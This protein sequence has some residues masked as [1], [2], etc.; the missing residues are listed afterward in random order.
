MARK[1]KTAALDKGVLDEFDALVAEINEAYAVAD[2]FGVKHP[3]VITADKAPDLLRIPTGSLGADYASGGGIPVRR[4]TQI[5]G[6][7]GS[8]KSALAT[9]IVAEAQRICPLC[10]YYACR[11]EDRFLAHVMYVDP[12]GT[13]DKRHAVSQGVQ[14]DKVLHMR[15]DYAE[16]GIDVCDKLLRSRKITLCVMDTLACLTPS[17]EI[18]ASTEKWQQGLQARLVN[19][20]LRKWVSALNLGGLSKKAGPALLLVN[21]IRMSIGVMFANPEVF[22]GGNGQKFAASIMFKNTAIEKGKDPDDKSVQ[23]IVARI[24]AEKNKT[25]PPGRSGNMKMW[26]TNRHPKHKMGEIEDAPQILE[27]AQR[28]ELVEV[29][30]DKTLIWPGVCEKKGLKALTFTRK[31]HETI[32]T[33]PQMKGTPVTAWMKLRSAVLNGMMGDDTHQQIRLVNPEHVDEDPEEDEL[34]IT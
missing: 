12:E 17:A 7:E 6:W 23:Y 16:Q 11:C 14:I 18:E 1:K 20:A 4:V 34:I 25:Y 10:Y 31:L 30:K 8:L 29:Q 24:K 19:K 22:P 27:L 32:V 2:E 21:Q 5:N 26:V 13:W 3:V 28:F 9:Q 33:G 15:P